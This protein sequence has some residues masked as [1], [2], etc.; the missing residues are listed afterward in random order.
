M[1]RHNRGG[2]PPKTDHIRLV[3]GSH[4]EDRHG[5]VEDA[6]RRLREASAGPVP[7]PPYWLDA[8]G[9]NI[10][11]KHAQLLHAEGNL[12]EHDRQAFALY[13]EAVSDFRRA[14][15]EVRARGYTLTDS[16]GNEKANPAVTAK[17]QAAR[18]VRDLS[19]EFNLTPLARARRP[20]GKSGGQQNLLEGFLK[21]PAGA[22]GGAGGE[23]S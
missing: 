17:N 20:S 5:S 21:G 15:R 16:H 9:K 14:E 2:R 3:T 18:R 23:S 13:C 8:I 11:R 6:K 4:R 10:W 19:I 12:T 7:R 1:S 22:A